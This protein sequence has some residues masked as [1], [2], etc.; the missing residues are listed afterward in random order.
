MTEQSTISKLSLVILTLTFGC[1]DPVEID[2]ES[3][4]D[5]LVIDGY[6]TN[7][8][9]PHEIT[10]SRTAP[11]NNNSID[12]PPSVDGA[13][14]RIT[15]DLGNVENLNPTG[16]G[17]YV[18]TP[19]FRGLVGRSYTLHVG[20]NDRTYES[21]AQMMMDSITIDSIY[22]E[23]EDREA[24]N[25]IQ[26]LVLRPWLNTY[27]NL[28]LPNTSSHVGITWEISCPPII[29]DC[30]LFI[31]KSGFG[32]V[33]DPAKGINLSN[34]FL[35]DF[36]LIHLAASL[37]TFT[38]TAFFHT[39]GE[40]AYNYYKKVDDQINSQGSVFDPLPFQIFGNIVNTTDPTEQVLG[41]FGA[42]YVQSQSVIVF[43]NN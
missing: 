33:V 26:Q 1:I 19:I 8:F 3:T 17:V 14:V 38:Y 16:D 6:I 28:S 42:H 11:F 2:F 7:E 43:I 23:I 36:P 15:D 13:T 35:D 34:E 32:K 29:P 18:T 30:G 37:G 40:E 5:F 12:L 25:F 24:F 20:I 21:S 31:E 41:F 4:Q 10:I 9:G 22:Y 27:G 39:F